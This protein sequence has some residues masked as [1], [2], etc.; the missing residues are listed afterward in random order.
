[1]K[2]RGGR[3]DAKEEAEFLQLENGDS[4]NGILLITSVH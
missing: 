4:E 2:K 1:M 3:K